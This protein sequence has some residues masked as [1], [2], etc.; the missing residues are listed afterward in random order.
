LIPTFTVLS[1]LW[2]L[3]EATIV[4]AGTTAPATANV[5][6]ALVTNLLIIIIPMIF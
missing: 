6:T 1:S 3:A 5:K 2:L 4:V